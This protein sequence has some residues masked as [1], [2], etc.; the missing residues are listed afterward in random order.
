MLLSTSYCQGSR[1]A[2]SRV[3]I[4]LS[5]NKSINNQLI[6]CWV[7]GNCCYL[8]VITRVEELP[9]VGVSISLSI[10]QSIHCWVE[11]NCCYL[12]VITRV[13]VLPTVGVSISLSINQLSFLPKKKSCIMNEGMNVSI[14]ESINH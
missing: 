6:H 2:Y 14:Y 12:L 7:E 9:T 8:L 4:N 5:I 1:V 13:V 3:S 11:G 10:N